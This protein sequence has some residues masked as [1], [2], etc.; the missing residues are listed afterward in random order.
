MIA[1]FDGNYLLHRAFHA[2]IRMYKIEHLRK[3][4]LTSFLSG[5]F[6]ISTEFRA[7][8]L[9]VCFDGAHS[10]RKD[11]DPRYKANRYAKTTVKNHLG[12][13]VETLETPGGLVKDAKKILDSYGVYYIHKKRFESDDTMAGAVTNTSKKC[14][15]VTRD[16]DLAG[17][18][19]DRVSLYWPVEKRIITPKEVVEHYGVTPS[20]IRDYLCLLGDKVDNIEGIKGWG[21]KTVQKFLKEHGTIKKALETKEGRY[22][23][24]PHKKIIFLSKKLVTLDLSTVPDYTASKYRETKEETDL[25]WRSPKSFEE[26]LNVMHKPKVKGLYR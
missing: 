15:I 26:Y 19:D 21:E 2:S 10:F 7:T 12:D 20:Q 11:I 9:I 14:V 3:N 23:L 6:S 1:V 5:V 13:E 22:R 4:A 25:I 16:K 8:H 24:M 18:V 17:M